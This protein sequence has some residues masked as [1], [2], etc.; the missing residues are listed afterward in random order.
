MSSVRTAAVAGLFYPADPAELQHDVQR[1]LAEAVLEDESSHC[2]KAVIVPHAGYIYSGSVAAR[3]FRQW[4]PYA[5]RI[6]RVV[7]LGPSH[8]VGFR[9]LALS[10]AATFETPLGPVPVDA[11][12]LTALADLP[13]VRPLD[14]AHTLEHCLEVQL[15]FLQN[16]LDQF[17]VVPLVVGDAA[18]EA[19]A[20]VIERLW[21][22]D[23][24]V[25]VIS[26]DLSHYLDYDAACVVDGL[27]CDAIETLDERAIAPDQACGRN[28]VRGLL[29][30]ARHHHLH[31]VT[32]GLCNSGDTAG[33][34]R[35][36]VGYG[37]WAFYPEATWH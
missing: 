31:P 18:P 15:P 4:R 10:Q 30:A 25:F 35:R 1:L 12:A 3:A 22:G 34:R 9:G 2:P 29:V 13:Q 23:D 8:R 21:G 5:H 37:A 14:E 24:T 19:V 26:S 11:T 36:V 16:V 28:P 32:L 27:T 17:T 6:H 20:A 7:L 33:D